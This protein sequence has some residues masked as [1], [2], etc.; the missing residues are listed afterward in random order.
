MTEKHAPLGPDALDA[1]LNALLAEH[2]AAFVAAI[3]ADGAFVPMRPA[4]DARRALAIVDPPGCL[5]GQRM[6]TWDPHDGN[7]VFGHR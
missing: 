3:N 1:A 2:P 4:R 5:I 7:V 6:P